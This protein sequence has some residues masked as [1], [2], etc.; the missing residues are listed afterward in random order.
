MSS[1]KSQITDEMKVAMRAKDKVRLGTIRLMLAELKR[2]EVDER[3]ELDD[4]RVLAVLDKMVK[5]RK[6]SIAQY[7]AAE[8]PE[9]AEKE[10]QETE[11]I[12]T[13]LP[14]P[15][16]DVEIDAIID[17]A[18]AATDASGMQAMGQVMA[19]I[20]PQLQGR[21]DMGAVSG[22]VKAKL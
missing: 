22:K 5:Q 9:L 2:I 18:I 14:Q 19:I 7:Q 4:D 3:I 15:L 11:V 21:A 13:F 12:K 10:Q 17:A 6:D 20:K 8:R 16:S 1:L